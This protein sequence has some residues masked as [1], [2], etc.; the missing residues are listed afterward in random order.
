MTGC[1]MQAR[2]LKNLVERYQ[3]LKSQASNKTRDRGVHSYQSHV[4]SSLDNLQNQIN[5]DTNTS[6]QDSGFIRTSHNNGDFADTNS[7]NGS[8]TDFSTDLM[9]DKE[10]WEGLLTDVGFWMSEGNNLFG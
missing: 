10:I 9:H 1:A 6:R 3:S 4:P 8:T 5:T 7:L 2:F